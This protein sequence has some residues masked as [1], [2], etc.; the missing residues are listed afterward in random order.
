VIVTADPAELSTV[1]VYRD[2]V[3]T[4]HGGGY[5]YPGRRVL[6]GIWRHPSP[7]VCDD[8]R[9]DGIWIGPPDRPAEQA[10]VCRSC[11]LDCT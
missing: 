6:A 1:I 3:V 7:E 11:G 8:D 5:V 4:H 9:P 10:L 2:Q